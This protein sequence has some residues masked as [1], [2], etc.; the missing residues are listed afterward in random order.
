L[1]RRER[2]YAPSLNEI[3]MKKKSKEYETF[4]GMVD[5]L[6]K[7]PHEEVRAK[8]EAE[9]AAKRRKKSRKSSA[10]EGQRWQSYLSCQSQ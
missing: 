7:V 1:E 4:T 10:L 2:I 3:A 8:L 5:A 9:K 6:L